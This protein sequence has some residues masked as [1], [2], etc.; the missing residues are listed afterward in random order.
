M[1]PVVGLAIV[2]GLRGGVS[3]FWIGPLFHLVTSLAGNWR[4]LS[5]L[6]F[7]NYLSDNAFAA[8]FVALYSGIFGM[9]VGSTVGAL[10]L[11]LT[12]DLPGNGR[13]L[14]IICGAAIGANAMLLLGNLGDSILGLL[15]GATVGAACAWSS[16]R[17]FSKHVPA[18]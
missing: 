2:S 9:A 15:F 10:L 6:G 5:R 14:L 11:I 8:P 17:Y 12:A 18:A 1:K 13:G 16:S 7:W 4:D 3:A